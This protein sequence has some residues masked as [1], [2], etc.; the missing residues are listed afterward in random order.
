MKHNKIGTIFMVSVLALAGIGISY[1]GFI[2]L[3]SVYGTVDTATVD[4]VVADY[5]GTD[6]WKVY[7]QGA[8]TGEI[9]VWHGFISDPDR[10]TQASLEALYPGCTVILVASSWASEGT[11]YDVDMVWDNIFP[12]IDFTADVIIHY[13]GTIPAHVDVTDLVWDHTGE[14]YD[15][16]QYTTFQVYQYIFVNDEWVKGNRITSF[17]I[18]MHLCEYI[19]IVVTIHLGQ[20]NALQGKHGEFSFNI[21]AMQWND[22]C[23][24][25]GG[26]E[27]KTITI[28]TDPLFVTM[29]V[30][31][32][33]PAG[34]G[35]FRTHLTNVPV[36]TWSPPIA[37]GADCVGWCVDNTPPGQYIDTGVPYK[38][39]LYDSYNLP[40]TLP[41]GWTAQP[42][43]S[44]ADWPKVNWILNNKGSATPTQIQN[45]IWKFIDGGYSGSDPVV[46]AL[47]AGANANPD[48]KPPAGQTPP[49]VIA[50][51]CWVDASVYGHK[52]TTII[53]VDP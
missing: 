23:D 37:E 16:S 9:V 18:Q 43:M 3:I 14:N 31:G 53:E 28:P 47:I 4:L 5:S 12:C 50:A 10:H 6:V 44:D 41:G 19:G 35:Y 30:Y 51:I 2:D 7:G 22:Q 42:W 20:N 46:L 8:P 17:P 32:P 13:A 11:D 38:T 21:N 15:F 34:Y 40:T 26:S 52:Q 33:F 27:F 49:A 1:A 25:G 29:R 48:Y 36:G 39:Y 45:A 24:D